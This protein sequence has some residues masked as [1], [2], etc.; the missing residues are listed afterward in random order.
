MLVLL[1]TFSIFL[2]FGTSILGRGDL[3]FRRSMMVIEQRSIIAAD[4]DTAIMIG[5]P[6]ISKNI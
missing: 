2:F 1:G 5:K 4:M 3:L 6:P